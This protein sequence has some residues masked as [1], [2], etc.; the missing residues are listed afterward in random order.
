MLNNGHN[1]SV[2]LLP[3]IKDKKECKGYIKLYSGL[4]NTPLFD[5]HVTLFGRLNIDP[6]PTYAFFNQ[7]KSEFNIEKVN[8]INIQTGESPWK[9]IHIKLDSNKYL[10]RLQRKIDEYFAKY[11]EYRFEPHISLAYGNFIPDKKDLNLL[12]IK[13]RISFTSLAIMHTPDQIK[14]WR[15]IK[16]FDFC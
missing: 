14:N 1:W 4:Y 7:L 5:P 8:N 13:K 16:K 10:V 2:W 6:E 9:T 3:G 11:R 15:L 12:L